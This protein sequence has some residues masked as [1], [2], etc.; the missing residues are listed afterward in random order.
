MSDATDDLDYINSG[1][2]SKFRRQDK[3]S[4]EKQ[5]RAMNTPQPDSSKVQ[6]MHIAPYFNDSSEVEGKLH[7]LIYGV[8]DWGN[9]S[10]KGLY[11]GN[12]EFEGIEPELAIA[13]IQSLI[14]EAKIDT[15][16]RLIAVSPGN[17]VD[18]IV[19]RIAQTH[20]EELTQNS[21]ESP[22]STP[23]EDF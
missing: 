5:K 1:L 20:L 23:K 16:E 21:T 14:R 11:F 9:S 17:P 4:W 10:G 15:L 3:A 2:A 22:N 6:K 18:D 8:Y 19:L 12:D 7:T 13:A